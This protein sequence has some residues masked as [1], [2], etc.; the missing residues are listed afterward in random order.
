MDKTSILLLNL[1]LIILQV[2]KKNAPAV[3]T[4]SESPKGDAEQTLGN[5]WK[6]SH[7]SEIF[8]DDRLNNRLRLLFSDINTSNFASKTQCVNSVFA[9]KY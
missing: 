3:N 8:W 1:F 5:T 6:N 7:S 9:G 2:R 4:D